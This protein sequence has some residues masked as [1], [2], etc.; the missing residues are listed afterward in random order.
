MVEILNKNVKD[1]I[2]QFPAIEK[3][4]TEQGIGCT[5]CSLGTCMLKDVVGIHNLSEDQEL[6]LMSR[7]AAIVFPGQKVEIPKIQRAARHKPANAKMSPPLR[8]LVEEHGIIKRFLSLVPVVIARFDVDP[9]EAMDI[10]RKGLAFIRNYADAFH[11]AKEEKIL[12]AF[13]DQNAD[14]I[15]SFLKEHTIGRDHGR[16]IEEGLLSNNSAAI[17]AH[18][19]AYADLLFEHIKK[20]D[21]ILYPWMDRS[22]SDSQVGQLFSKFAVINNEYESQTKRFVAFVVDLETRFNRQTIAPE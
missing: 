15:Q 22:L 20:E 7:I 2:T 3:V 18:C 17:K 9:P 4:L 11:H 8:E 6:A 19:A 10:V 13:F 21:E 16:A 12:F 5:T 1:V 14:V